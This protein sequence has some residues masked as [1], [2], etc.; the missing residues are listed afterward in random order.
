M[1]NLFTGEYVKNSLNVSCNWSFIKEIKDYWEFKTTARKY[2]NQLIT[3]QVIVKGIYDDATL[4]TTQRTVGMIIGRA[5]FL[6]PK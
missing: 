1:K 3:I 4:Y 5:V 2:P 6:L